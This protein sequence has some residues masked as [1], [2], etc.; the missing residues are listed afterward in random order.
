MT[1]EKI[2]SEILSELERAKIKYPSHYWPWN[3]N[4]NIFEMCALVGVEAGE[5]MQAANK[6]RFV[7]VDSLEHVKQELIQTASTAIRVLEILE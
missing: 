2:I 7:G 6:L 1:K 4:L 3:G 5:A